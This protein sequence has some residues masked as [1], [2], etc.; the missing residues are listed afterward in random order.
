MYNGKASNVK[1]FLKFSK[2]ELRKL[3]PYFFYF[4]KHFKVSAFSIYILLKKH[5]EPS[6][7]YLGVLRCAQVHQLKSRIETIPMYIVV[8]LWC[9]FR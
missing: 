5:T 6:H 3:S 2:C 8:S 1:D 9:Y 7:V 4:F